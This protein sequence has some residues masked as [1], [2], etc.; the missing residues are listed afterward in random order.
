MQKLCLRA[1]RREAGGTALDNAQ[2]GTARALDGRRLQ[3]VDLFLENLI[4]AL[5]ATVFHNA[6]SDSLDTLDTL[7]RDTRGILG[8]YGA[9]AAD[10]DGSN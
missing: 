5:M 3:A 2:I 8:K 9:V 4:Y 10:L 1:E 7:S 6:G